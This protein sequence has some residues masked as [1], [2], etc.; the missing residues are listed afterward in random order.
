LIGVE[1]PGRVSMFPVVYNSPRFNV[2][3]ELRRVADGGKANP[4]LPVLA[5]IHK[6]PDWRYEQEWRLIQ[7]DRRAV[8]GVQIPM[9]VPT[10]VTLGARCGECVR[11]RVLEI[12]A[13]QRFP[14][15]EMR[16]SSSNFQLESVLAE[17]SPE[18]RCNERTRS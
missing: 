3:A 9:S 5:A 15:Y 8:G 10:S 12:A 14:V 6:S 17:N 1:D 16:L 2:A 4:E 7:R 11:S 13:A 18:E